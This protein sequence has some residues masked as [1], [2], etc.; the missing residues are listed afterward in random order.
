MKEFAWTQRDGIHLADGK[1]EKKTFVVDPARK[2]KVRSW[3]SGVVS[4]LVD[5]ELTGTG[6]LRLRTG[7]YVELSNSRPCHLDHSTHGQRYVCPLKRGAHF[8]CSW[9]L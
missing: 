2:E 6:V 5:P 1:R 7:V 4:A 9:S 3:S 8:I